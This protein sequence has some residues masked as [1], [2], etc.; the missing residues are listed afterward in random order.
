MTNGGTES[1]GSIIGNNAISAI[2][3]R[4]YYDGRKSYTLVN[5]RKLFDH[6]LVPTDYL[7]AAKLTEDGAVITAIGRYR[8]LKADGIIDGIVVCG[9]RHRASVGWPEGELA[10][11]PGSNSIHEL[12]AKLGLDLDALYN[13]DKDKDKEEQNDQPTVSPD[14]P[15]LRANGARTGDIV[16]VHNI[17]LRLLR[18]I[19]Y[20]KT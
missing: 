9:Y 13:S 4:Y 1:I 5:L 19:G 14:V 20:R 18:H 10:W 12:S 7:R 15:T 11:M 17:F 2:W 3:A 16:P 8:G 6:L